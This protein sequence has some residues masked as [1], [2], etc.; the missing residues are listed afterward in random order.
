MDEW[1]GLLENPCFSE[2]VELDITGGEPFLKKDL[3]VF[4]KALATFKQKHLSRL[5]SVAITTNAILTDQVLA[6]TEEIIN[7]LE[8][9][10]IQLVLA[11]AMDAVDDRHD[12]IRNL[13]GA[14]EKMQATLAG[15]MKLRERYPRLIL[16]LKTTILPMNVDQ[17]SEIDQFA[18]L[19]NLFG[20][21]SP[22]IITG[23]RYLN[24]DLG[25]DLAFS[26]LDRQKMID[27]FNRD[28]LRWSYHARTLK[29]YLV[30]GRTRR[31]CSCGFNYAFIRSSGEVHPCPLL[32][33]S[34]G[35]VRRD[36]FETIWNSPEAR[37]L[38]G[39]IGR[40]ETCRHCTEP[41]LER[42]SLYYEG[43]TYLGM[44][45]QMGPQRFAEFHQHM[46]LGH[47]FD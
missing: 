46:G 26:A 30:S 36:D 44:M 13:K 7:I 43:W 39:F 41:G 6:A 29:D 21:I 9:T 40:T 27:F 11:C 5:K 32:P 19:H 1:A 24:T 38:R 10:G 28:D 18:R 34:A 23:G 31:R 25:R 16:G 12:R 20:I 33:E 2:L 8:G 3:P 45:L 4:F 42:Y 17:L 22:C 14:F 47:Y 35:S 15:L 37:R